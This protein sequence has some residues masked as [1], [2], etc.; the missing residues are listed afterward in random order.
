MNFETPIDFSTKKKVSDDVE[1]SYSSL[2]EIV[3]GGAQIG[4]ISINGT[5]LSNDYFGGPFIY[6]DGYLYAPKFIRKFLSSGFR[7]SRINVRTFDISMIG[8]LKALIFLE[9]IVDNKAFYFE[10]M[11]KEKQGAIKL[12]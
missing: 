3:Q 6:L 5:L 11:N 12:G 9:K 10:D 7:L 4:K 8:K 2:T 1:I